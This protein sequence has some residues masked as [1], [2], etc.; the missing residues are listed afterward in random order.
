MYFHR[1]KFAND[2]KSYVGGLKAMLASN[3]TAA[4]G[5]VLNNSSRGKDFSESPFF[6]PAV[7]SWLRWRPKS[8]ATWLVKWFVVP[9]L[10]IILAIY[11]LLGIIF[12]FCLWTLALVPAVIVFFLISVRLEEARSA[13]A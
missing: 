12:K 6:L 10:L 7:R 3:W 8:L 13:H 5:N 2:S 4:V 1:Q 11:T 9:V